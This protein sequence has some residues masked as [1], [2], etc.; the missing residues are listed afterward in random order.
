MFVVFG[1]MIDDPGSA[2]V[3]VASAKILGT[4]LLAGRG[5]DKRWSGKKDR[6]LVSNDHTLVTHRR[7]IGS[8]GR[9]T[10]HY[11]RDLG[12][13]LRTHLRLVEKDSAEMI[14]IGKDLRLVRQIGTPAIDQINAGQSIGF[15]NFLGSEM[16][17]HSHRII[18]ATFDGRVI[19]HDH[20]LPARHPS[21]PAN[22]ACTRHLAI[23]HV[24]SGELANLKEWRAGIEQSLDT[25]ARKQFAARD[26]TFPMF[27]KT[28]LGGLGDI[29]AKLLGERAVVRETRAELLAVRCDYAVDPRRAHATLVSVGRKGLP[30]N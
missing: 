24:A 20:R 18:S 5:F 23:I 21:N 28:P 25:I 19:A 26:M 6:A 8:A 30:S 4:D 3:K 11:A 16:L 12:D 14:P 13:A 15:G 27:F 22:D 2:G 1:E 7:D 9:T 29:C 10:T 17:L